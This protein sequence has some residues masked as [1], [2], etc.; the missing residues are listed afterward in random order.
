ME[1]GVSEKRNQ[2]KHRVNVSLLEKK[3]KAA[4][5]RKKE[6]KEKEYGQIH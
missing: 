1:V 4:A 3:R 2:P 5:E 6:S